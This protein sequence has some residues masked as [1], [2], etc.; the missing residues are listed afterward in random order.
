MQK[1]AV[2]EVGKLCFVRNASRTVAT[3]P[4][5]TRVTVVEDNGEWLEVQSKSGN[6][7]GFI[8]RADATFAEKSN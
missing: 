1:C 3:I 5:G 7:P 6:P 4:Q 2:C 8:R